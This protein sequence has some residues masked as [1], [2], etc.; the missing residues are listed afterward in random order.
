M[1]VFSRVAYIHHRKSVMALSA[2]LVVLLIG[3]EI[4]AIIPAHATSFPYYVTLSTQ[5]FGTQVLAASPD[6]VSNPSKVTFSLQNG[7]LLWYGID[8]QSD[9]SGLKV[10]AADPADDLVSSTLGSFGLL[11]PTSVIP[12]SFNSK[13]SGVTYQ[14]ETLHLATSFSSANQE[15][16]ITLNP[17]DFN[18]AALDALNLLSS[19]LGQDVPKDDVFGR[20]FNA[21][22]GL[23]GPNGVKDILD[24]IAK[25]QNLVSFTN[26]FAQV[27]QAYPDKNAMLEHA[28]DCIVDLSRL[29][30]NGEEMQDFSSLLWTLQGKD[31]S[32]NDISDDLA[33]FSSFWRVVQFGVQVG[34]FIVDEASAI[35]S[36]LFTKGNPTVTLQTIPVIQSPSPT[37]TLSSSLMSVDWANFTYSSSCYGIRQTY[38]VHNGTAMVNNIFFQVEKP[39]FGDLTGDGQ[40][41]AVIPYSCTGAD[42]GGESVF[43][44]TGDATNPM[45]IGD[46]PTSDQLA[47]NNLGSVE[48]VTINNSELILSGKA[49]GLGDAQCCPSLQYTVT[50]RWNGSAFVVVNLS[51]VSLTPTPQ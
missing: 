50:Y 22:I 45:L 47:N 21:M 24:T 16:Q 9:P 41:E 32:L 17:L 42:F 23:L 20:N 31:V 19:I 49:Y 5:N 11:P 34:S 48:K 7:T 4:F 40:P 29:L 3:A 18:A 30:A 38:H 27:L 51:E 1:Q 35:G 39:V 26:D 2:V 15:I 46:L 13:T 12:L 33:D 44:Y 28:K 14:F 37:P 25:L 8:T 43:V 6:D 36:I 10:E